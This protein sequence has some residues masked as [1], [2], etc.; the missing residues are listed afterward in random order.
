MKSLGYSLAVM[1]LIGDTEAI[2]IARKV[3]NVELLDRDVFEENDN[4]DDFM[5]ESIAEAEKENKDGKADL[6]AQI[7]QLDAD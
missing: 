5:A 7:A 6:T 1:A 2:K 4:S 3:N